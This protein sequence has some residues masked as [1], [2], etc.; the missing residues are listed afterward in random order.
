VVQGSARAV[1]ISQYLARILSC[2]S[3]LPSQVPTSCPFMAVSSW[4]TQHCTNLRSLRPLAQ[5]VQEKRVQ[6]PQG[7]VAVCRGHHA[8]D[9][10]GRT[11]PLLALDGLAGSR[12]QW[13]LICACKKVGAQLHDW[14]FLVQAPPQSRPSPAKYAQGLSF[15]GLIRMAARAYCSSAA[16]TCPLS[17]TGMGAGGL[18][19]CLVK[20]GYWQRLQRMRGGRGRKEIGEHKHALVPS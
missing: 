8:L 9:R 4:P 10:L 11:W 5:Q 6:V 13:G 7:R 19:L 3:L 1:R 20:A 18:S 15:V 16:N 14:L 17:S 2:W 12:L